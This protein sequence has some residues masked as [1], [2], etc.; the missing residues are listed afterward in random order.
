MTTRRYHIQK[1]DTLHDGWGTLR[2]ITYETEDERG[3]KT[4]HTSE[5]YDAGDAA[6]ILLYNKERRTVLLV[7]QLRIASALNGHTDGFLLEVPAGKIEGGLSPEE[8]ARKEV[9]EETGYRIG[10]LAPVQALFSSPGAFSEKLHLFT[11]P[12]SP[13]QKVASG[14]GRADEGEATEI[15]ELPVAEALRKLR[16]GD[17]LDAKTVLLLQHGVLAGLLQE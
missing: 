15:V 14:G 10:T 12:Y 17:F 4:G 8:T 13:D 6:G 1:N 16:A 7:R 9:L 11:A 2:A 5:V 3:R